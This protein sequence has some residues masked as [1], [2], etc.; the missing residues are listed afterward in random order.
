MCPA[1][2]GGGAL[3]NFRTTLAT[4]GKSFSLLLLEKNR[5]FSAAQNLLSFFSN[6]IYLTKKLLECRNKCVRVQ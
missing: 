6:F 5:T 1:E 4:I 2:G 3:N